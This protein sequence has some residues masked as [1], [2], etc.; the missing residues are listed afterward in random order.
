MRENNGEISVEHRLDGRELRQHLGRTLAETLQ[1]VPGMWQSSM[2]PAP[3]RPVLRGLSGDRLLVLED[4]RTTGDISTSSPDHALAI[5]PIN[6]EHIEIL[7]GPAA[8]VYSSN[9]IAGVVNVVRGQIPTELPSHFH[10]KGS[11]QGESV[12]TGLSAGVSTYGSRKNMGIKADFGLRTASDIQTPTGVLDNT[13]IRNYHGALGL[14]TIRSW[15]LFGGSANFYQSAYGVP[16]NFDGSHPDGVKINLTRVQSDLRLDY[17]STGSWYRRMLLDYTFSYYFHEELEFSPQR[18][19]FDIVGSEYWLFTNSLR[20]KFYHSKNGILPQGIAGF[21]LEHSNYTSGG[22]TFTPQ[23]N[24]L[25]AA[26]YTWQQFDFDRLQLQS[27]IRVDAY[28][29]L[30][31]EEVETAIGLRRQRDFLNISGGLKS[32]L[33]LTSSLSTGL[34]L[35]RTVRMPGVEELFSEG[36]HLPSYSFEIGNPDLNEEI[37]H[38]IEWNFRFASELFGIQSALYYNHFSNYLY[39]RNTGEE[40]VRR[41]LPIYQFSGDAARMMGFEVLAEFQ[42]IRELAFSG[43]LGY[44][45]GDLT[46]LDEPIPFIPPVTGKVDAQ[47]AKNAITFGI[48]M[49]F[50]GPQNRL[51][52][53]EEATDGYTVFDTF[54]QYYISSGR[55]LHTFSITLENATNATYRMHLSRVKSIMPEPGRNLKLLYRVYW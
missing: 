35:M 21:Q 41:P 14:S 28:S 44:V 24:D 1:N 34:S 49:R 45:R 54:L 8:L 39:P 4:G 47:F 10:G 20:G 15:G 22:F 46:E 31:V 2:G 55:Q 19:A 37:G 25:S 9:S 29:I 7:R 13:Y 5:D 32:T 36:P 27:G 30:P 3:A 26:V 43:T 51:G 12:N 48:G 23:T 42:P 18:Q 52:E 38:G 17:N 11:I 53:F 40:S 16:G 33:R 6:S 50:A